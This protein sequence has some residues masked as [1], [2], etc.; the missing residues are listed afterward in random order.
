MS[1]PFLDIPVSSCDS[2]G[3]KMKKNLLKK[4]DGFAFLLPLITMLLIFI[5]K[6]IYPFGQQ[7]FLRT[8]LYHQYAP[9][10]REFQAK[11]QSFSPMS[12]SFHLGLGVNFTALYAYY[13]ASPLNLFIFFFPKGL[14][15]E[16][17]SYLIVFKIALCGC[18]ASI[19]FR[20]HFR[21][22]GYF[23]VIFGI[24]YALSG[25]IAAYSWNVMWL[26]C[27]FLFPLLL[28]GLEYMMERRGALLYTVS[29]AL[30]ILCNYYISIMICLFLIL[31]FVSLF[32]D[33]R[34]R[35]GKEIGR[36]IGDFVLYSFL[37][38]MMAAVLLLP[39]IFT[40]RLTASSDLSFPKTISQYF[41][42]IDMM[43]RLLPF[44][45]TEQG[46]KHWPN[47]YAG[48]LSLF[49]L[50]LYFMNPAIGR[51]KKMIYGCF[52]LIF[53]LSFSVNVL[54]FIWHGLHYPNSLP[55]RQSF[56]FIFLLLLMGAEWFL[57]RKYNTEKELSIS[58]FLS[59]FFVIL[60]QKLISDQAFHWSVFYLA[61]AFLFLYYLIFSLEKKGVT[62]R[63]TNFLLLGLCFLELTANMAV[64]SVST[65]SRSAYLEGGKETEKIIK[66]IKKEDL[67]FYRLIRED[68][69]TKDDGALMQYPSASIFSSTAYGNITKCFTKLGMEASTNAYSVQGATPLTKMLLGIKYE[70]LKGEPQ[71]TK[72]VGLSYRLAEGEYLL[73]KNEYVLPVGFLLTEDALSDFDLNAGNPALVQNSIASALGADAVLHPI[74]GK[75]ESTSYRFSVDEP[76]DI[77][78]YVNNSK[79]KD[80][81]AILPKKELHFENVNRGYFLHLGYLEAGDEVE[82]KSETD[83]ESMD[84]I[85]YTFSFEALKKM[86]ERLSTSSLKLTKWKDGYLKG[87]ISADSDGVL[88]TSIPYDPGWKLMV[89]G[90]KMETREVFGGFMGVSLPRGEHEISL[91]FE[92][93]GARF[94]LLVSVTAV[95]FFVLLCIFRK[96][97]EQDKEKDRERDRDI[98]RDRERGEIN[99]RREDWKG[100]RH[101]ID[102][103]LQGRSRRRVRE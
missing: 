49:I 12:Y 46:L 99:G 52:M 36:R 78:V 97:E 11:L 84:A 44:V 9:F 74:L 29:L 15:V 71:Y 31:Y 20:R 3:E 87:K 37:S 58:L 1:L 76:G 88:F 80:V 75:M 67:G 56:I 17:V 26:D 35:S 32:F 6:G 101:L 94:A 28:L 86:E 10:L 34:E 7:S 8:D 96:R 16:F 90:K 47:I 2:Q 85:A 79:V 60:C 89:D 68:S 21:R 48:S 22:G 64:T 59:F 39:A 50:P 41:G 95:L 33:G 72:E 70:I 69:K 103:N 92:A 51:R 102:R 66:E 40:L 23:S 62:L 61:L 45:E 81:K 4:E 54:N 73:Y 93:E 82:M 19:Y 55:A 77:Y 30:S 13:L 83:S 57:K 98:E 91:R 63:I 14:V 27:L 18:S 100:N 42:I 24:L 5:L 65:T 25:Y 43:A 38:G 53:F